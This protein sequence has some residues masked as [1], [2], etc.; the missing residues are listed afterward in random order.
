MAM[1]MVKVAPF[2]WAL[3][4]PETAE[5]GALLASACSKHA[6]WREPK[7]SGPGARIRRC[8]GGSITPF[9]RRFVMQASQKVS[10]V[11]T[12]SSPAISAELSHTRDQLGGAPLS[13]EENTLAIAG[14]QRNLHGRRDSRCKELIEDCR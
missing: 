12:D 7:L 8:R 11:F 3:T 4:A 13:H 10:S 14:N 2:G 5:C 1:R 9:S 6:F